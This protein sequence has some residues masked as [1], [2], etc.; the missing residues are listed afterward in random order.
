MSE[1]PKA[2]SLSKYSGSSERCTTALR[3]MVG[4]ERK[5]RPGEARDEH[6]HWDK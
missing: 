6:K 5:G 3:W 1:N 2:V 4:W